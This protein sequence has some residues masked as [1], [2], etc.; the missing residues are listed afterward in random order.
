ML[1]GSCQS[2]DVSRM[3]AMDDCVVPGIVTLCGPGHHRMEFCSQANRNQHV[4]ISPEITDLHY[5]MIKSK[6]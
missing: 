5:S 2:L 3:V 1:A 6:T 4:F